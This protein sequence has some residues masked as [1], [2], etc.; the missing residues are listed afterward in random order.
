L[1]GPLVIAHHHFD[2]VG[3]VHGGDGRTAQP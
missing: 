1:L 2:V 3:V